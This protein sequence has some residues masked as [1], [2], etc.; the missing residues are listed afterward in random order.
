MKNKVVKVPLSS[1]KV[2]WCK[3]SVGN[4]SMVTLAMFLQYVESECEVDIASQLRNLQVVPSGSKSI[5]K[6]DQDE[7]VASM[8]G[9]S[10]G[11]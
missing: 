9:W 4:P 11:T 8:R 7:T 2:S 5:A 1:Q 6:D 3:P 10:E